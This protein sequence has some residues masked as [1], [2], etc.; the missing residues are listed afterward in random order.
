MEGGACDAEAA[1][2]VELRQSSAAEAFG[3]VADAD[4]RQLRAR[5]QVKGAEQRQTG[6]GEEGAV[7]QTGQ[8]GE[9][10]LGEA[11]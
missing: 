2:E 11:L 3:E 7:R 1:F 9:L 10:H 5:G 6:E 8:S 4:V